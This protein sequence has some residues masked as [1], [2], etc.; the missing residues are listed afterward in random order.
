MACQPAITFR[1]PAAVPG[2]HTIASRLVS[3][4]SR[5]KGATYQGIPAAKIPSPP[6]EVSSALRSRMA[7][8]TKP[9]KCPLSLWMADPDACQSR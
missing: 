5:P 8:F 7:A 2:F 6:M 1:Q 4:E 3:R 9:L